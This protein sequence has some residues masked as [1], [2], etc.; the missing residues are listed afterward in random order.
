VGPLIVGLI[1]DS[2]G[3][4]RYAF[5]FLVVMIWS[6]VPVLRSVNVEQ[7]RKD[8]REYRYLPASDNTNET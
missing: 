6:A 3:N 4:I 7:G 2:T 1:S 8:A 5:F